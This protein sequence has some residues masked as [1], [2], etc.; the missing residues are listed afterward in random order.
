[1]SHFEL[2]TA[3]GSYRWYY[4]DLTSGDSTAV[5]IFMIGSIFSPR[6]SR[7]SGDPRAHAAVNFAFYQRGQRRHWVLSEYPRVCA[8]G[9]TL[10]IGGSTMRAKPDGTV[11]VEID[12]ATAVWRRPLRVS[13]ELTPEG[14]GHAPIRL[15][16][17][18]E[19][20]WQ[21][22]APRA[23]A[24]M[25]MNDVKLEG[26]GYHDGNHGPVRLGSDLRGWDWA[27]SH[28]PGRTS[29][30]YRPWRSELA[31]QVEVDA[32]SLSVTQRSLPPSPSRRTAWGLPV[33]R[34]GTLL[35]SSP[36]YAR[37]ESGNGTLGEVADFQR[38]HSPW[39]RW[40]AGLR[41]RVAA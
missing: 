27:R 14:P 6:Y 4:F 41:T 13:L 11:Q 19:H 32:Q 39:I 28:T 26:R 5:A 20:Y 21:P 36:F 23:R 9:D 18:L 37:L 30:T 33:P 1:M 16:D 29:I 8:K 25:T 15:V 34:G 24:T 2:P 40:M 35:E 31:W 7:A 38:F 10:A 22:I 17:G 3:P 12:D